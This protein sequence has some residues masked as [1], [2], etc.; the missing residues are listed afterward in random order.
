MDCV[1]QKQPTLAIRSSAGIALWSTKGPK[2]ALQH[3]PELPKEDTKIAR[4]ITYSPDGKYLAYTN[5]KDVK[6]LTTSDWQ[7][8]CSLPR[9]KAFYL[10]FSP[11][12]T[13]LVTWELYMV[14]KDRP[15]GSNNMYVYKC[16]SGEEVFS[17]VQK[18]QT[19]WEPSW[20]NDESLF[21]LMVGGEAFFYELPISSA[22]P[23]E[24]FLTK[25]KT[26]GCGRGGVLSLAP[27]QSPPYLAFYTP[28]STKGAPS[29]CK[30][31]K[32]PNLGATETVACKSFFQCDN[33]EMKWN[34][35]GNGLLILTSTEVDKTGASYYGNQALHFM[36]TKG[37]SCAITLKK[38]GPIH[39]VQWSPK[40][41]EFVVVYGYM[42]SS[43][44]LFNLKCDPI[45]SFTD[46]PMNCA[47]FNR[48]GNMIL[49][50]GFGNLRGVV[51]VWDLTRKFKLA[52]LEAPDSTYVEWSP[53]GEE[54]ITATTAPR[55]R[56][57]NGFKV[58]HYSGALL[59][60]TMWEQGQELYGVEWQKFADGFF[61]ENPISR[62]KVEGIKSS[63]PTASKQAYQPPNVRMM[64]KGDGASGGAF[65]PQSTI[66]G[67]PP[68]NNY[69][70]N[71]NFDSSRNYYLKR[72]KP[73]EK[74]N[75]RK[76]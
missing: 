24:G 23:E 10:K 69:S 47:H 37:D 8:K 12:G 31:Y 32:Y 15:E 42:P 67:L 72:Y 59:H 40:G 60:E 55:L 34:K 26:I 1:N 66:P 11:R 4:S 49:L 25:V 57:S 44:T 51:S 76:K 54:F 65:V 35:R 58:W 27:G 52:T 3:R 46:G 41:N 63:Q 2:D 33:V 74:T 39:D 38:E 30:I 71:K 61:K 28:G 50:G 36:A 14:T 73:Y 56:I 64:M 17:V 9:P 16:E 68:G 21:A 18:K 6:I 22:K 19:D 43:A 29:M 13:F 45:F 70:R 53:T 75:W 7:L 62:A 5:G 48:F 20:A